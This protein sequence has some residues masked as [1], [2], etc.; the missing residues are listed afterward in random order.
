MSAARLA[1]VGV[2]VTRPRAEA[3][4]LAAALER[5][6]ARCHVFPALAIEPLPP[7]PA[8]A[9]ALD[10]LPT[11]PVAIFVSANAVTH[12]L[13][14]AARR[15]PWPEAVAVAAVGEATG[16]ALRAAGFARVVLPPGGGADSEALLEA[17]ALQADRVSGQNVVVFRGAG[18]RERLREVLEARGARVRYAEC[19]RR[20]R[21]ALDAGEL[22]AAWRRG[23]VHAV[24]ALSGETLANFVSLAGDEGARLMA[25]TA[26][27]VPHAAVAAHP[28]ARRFARVLVA[29]GDVH[30]IAGALSQLRVT[31]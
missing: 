7:T 15:G 31:T 3:E 10:A 29:P 1:G 8:L 17:P 30:G 11:A 6:G 20:V 4:A 28:D 22:L 25:S 12:G 5:E 19:Y 24:S 27:V 21:P 9:E 2:V 16:A 23:E 18:G 13:A 26:L 14:A